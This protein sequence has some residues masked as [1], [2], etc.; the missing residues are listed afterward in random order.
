M[1]TKLLTAYRKRLYPKIHA[2]MKKVTDLL[3]GGGSYRLHRN[4]REASKL[5]LLHGAAR[6]QLVLVSQ[7]TV[8]TILGLRS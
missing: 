5:V 3:V 4:G 6:C 2:S 1:K 7:W 8:A